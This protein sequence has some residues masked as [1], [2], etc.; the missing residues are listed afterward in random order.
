MDSDTPVPGHGPSNPPSQ[1]SNVSGFH[2]NLRRK[3]SLYIMNYF[4][5]CCLMVIVS[6]CSFAVRLL[7]MAVLLM[8]ILARCGRTWCPAAWAC[9]SPCS[10]SSST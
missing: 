1:T 10:S 5:P 2:L 8:N 6:W 4:L 3:Q 7:F 9:S